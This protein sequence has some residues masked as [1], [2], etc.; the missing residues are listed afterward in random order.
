MSTNLNRSTNLQ[1]I[2]IK[3]IKKKKNNE[4]EAQW[5]QR[6]KSRESDRVE[7]QKGC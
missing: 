1:N 3:L 4:H 7:C 6:A 2:I 5:G